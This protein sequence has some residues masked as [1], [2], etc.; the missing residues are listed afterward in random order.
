MRDLIKCCVMF[1]VCV[2]M[3]VVYLGINKVI[4][5]LMFEELLIV[6]KIEVKKKA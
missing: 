4:V 5:L 1:L 2:S 6:L 3:V